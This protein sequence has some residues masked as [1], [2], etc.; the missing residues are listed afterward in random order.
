M[1]M[2][3]KYCLSWKLN[4]FV[5]LPSMDFSSIFFSDINDH[6]NHFWLESYLL[7]ILCKNPEMIIKDLDVF[8]WKKDLVFWFV[9]ICSLLLMAQLTVI[10]HW[11][12]QQALNPS[13]L[14]QMATISQ[15]TF[16]NAF[17]WMKSFVFLFQYHWILFLR[18]Q[19]TIRQHW[20]G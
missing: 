20:F 17:S 1:Y 7:F 11:F 6:W 3:I 15:T 13:P 10:Q 14:D 18:V 4:G 9:F 12:I 5:S 8:S 16:S 2:L 19:F